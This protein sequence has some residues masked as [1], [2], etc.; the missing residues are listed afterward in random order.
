MERLPA[1]CRSVAALDIGI[2]DLDGDRLIDELHGD[3]Q[4]VLTGGD[5]DQLTLGADE[6]TAPHL[7]A[8][9]DIEIGMRLS[10]KGAREDPVDCGSGIAH[11]WPAS[12]TRRMT[13]DARLIPARTSP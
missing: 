7:D 12:L 3:D 1:A 4:L 13:P 9:P 5:A 11:G 8:V 2:V 10:L 6:R